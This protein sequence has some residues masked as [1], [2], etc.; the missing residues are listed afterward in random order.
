M[1]NTIAVTPALPLFFAD[2]I[3]DWTNTWFRLK[4]FFPKG[5][6]FAWTRTCA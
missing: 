1:P 4:R 6:W 5:G 2:R 3:V